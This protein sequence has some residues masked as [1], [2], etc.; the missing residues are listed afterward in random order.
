MLVTPAS[1]RDKII[2][3]TLG[4]MMTGHE[5][6]NKTMERILA[7]YWWPG[8]TGQID[9]HISVCEKCQKTKIKMK[10][11]YLLSLFQNYYKHITALI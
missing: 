10:T 5:S 3:D 9:C 7:S 11:Q 1:L 6:S 2:K 8:M 4:E